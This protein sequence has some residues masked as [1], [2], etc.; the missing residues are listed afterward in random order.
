M[1]GVEATED[2]HKELVAH[3]C[4]EI[5]AVASLD[6]IQFK[7][8]LPKTRSG[9]VMRRTLRKIGENDSGTIGNTS[10]LSIRP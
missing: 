10:I 6:K 1:S 4:K 9:E 3:V 8:C 2:L 5:Y 7:P